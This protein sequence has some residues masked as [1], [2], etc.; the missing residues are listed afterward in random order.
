M[1]ILSLDSVS[2][3][4][5]SAFTVEQLVERMDLILE[6]RGREH[7]RVRDKDDPFWM[8]QP[9]VRDV[10]DSLLVLRL[11]VADRRNVAWLA[12]NYLMEMDFIFVASA[13]T[14]LMFYGYDSGS[15][16]IDR[17][18]ALRINEVALTQYQVIGSR[19]AWE[20][21]MDL[22]HLIDKGKELKPSGRHRSKLAACGAWLLRAENPFSYFGRHLL[23]AYRV[24]RWHRSPEV[25]AKSHLIR[26]VLLLRRD[27]DRDAH[28]RVMLFSLLLNSWHPLIEILHERKPCFLAS[29]AGQDDD[30]RAWLE[31]YVSGDA[32]RFQA[33]LDEIQV[34]TKAIGR[35]TPAKA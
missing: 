22:M 26:E 9:R 1:P 7:G 17:S 19:I 24:D 27:S 28:E 14:N 32:D 34:R 25:H 33:L 35:G 2:K 29:V 15:I 21:L 31:A 3:E 4:E 6:T 23:A 18:P 5:L 11:S 16:S 8:A 12:F 20:C 10:M 30:G 13:A